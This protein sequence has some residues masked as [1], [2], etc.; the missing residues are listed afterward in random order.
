R[1]PVRVARPGHVGT[2]GLA[3]RRTFLGAQVRGSCLRSSLRS[4]GGHASD[5]SRGA[6]PSLRRGSGDVV[7]RVRG[8]KRVAGGLELPPEGL[9]PVGVLAAAMDDLA[10]V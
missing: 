7:L 2:G 6:A 5:A 8:T 10:Q 1:R 3:E 9:E 4:G